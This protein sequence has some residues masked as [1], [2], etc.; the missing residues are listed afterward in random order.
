MSLFANMKRDEK[1]E[2]IKDNVGGYKVLDS[3]VYDAMIKVVYAFQSDKGA[4]G[5]KMEFQLKDGT[6]YKETTYI[7]KQTGENY[8]TRNGKN[9]YLPG[10]IVVDELCAVATEQLL[11]MQE[12]DE[13]IVKEYDYATK[14]EVEKEVPV[15]TALLGK[16]VKLG[17]QKQL[18]YKSEKQPDGSYALVDE[19]REIN[20]IDKVFSEDGF[21]T[22]ELLDNAEE[23]K[24]LDTWTNKFNGVVVDKTKNKKPK[25]A[26]KG[27]GTG[28][29]LQTG[30]APK[31]LFGTKK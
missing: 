4:Q 9:F 8:Y 3:G 29:P 15:L 25:A 16:K 30:T 17:I 26:A 18:E 6:V 31:S 24:R 11:A 22:N 19:T 20:V 7:S 13:R 28:S 12:T 27:S 14:G 5:I 23:A 10:F 1:V 21:T 2:E